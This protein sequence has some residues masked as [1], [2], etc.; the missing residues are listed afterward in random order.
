M[1]KV[2]QFFE[3]QTST[4]TY[5]VYEE[6]SK[7]A[8]IIDS[9]Y[10]YT[11]EYLD[12]IEKNNLKL[13]YILETH[14]HADHTTDAKNLKE[15][16]NAL[17]GLSKNADT[18]CQDLYLEEGS[19][20]NIGKEEIK[21]LETFGHTDTCIT[22]NIS[23]YL[24]TGDALL[25]NGSGRTDFQAGDS[26]LLYKSIMRMYEFE[27]STVIYP[28]HDYKGNKFSTIKEQKENNPRINK[29]TKLEEFIE[30]MENLNLPDPKNIKK[31]VPENKICGDV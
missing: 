13:K 5:I 3:K 27:D 7:E 14:I 28:A 10:G 2:E 9:V 25:I 17:I 1:I 6:K 30:I 11:K 26:K 23:N 24:F 12:Y 20:I 21:V 22:F 8:V 18:K 4:Y 29:D 19:V 16:T 31:A 15:K